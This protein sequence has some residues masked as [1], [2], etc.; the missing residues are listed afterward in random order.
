MVTKFCGTLH[1]GQTRPPV[2]QQYVGYLCNGTV[3]QLNVIGF[4]DDEFP[5]VCPEPGDVGTACDEDEECCSDQW[6]YYETHDHRTA[7]RNSH[8]RALPGLRTRS[9][10]S[11]EPFPPAR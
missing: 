11:Q 3:T 4:L 9:S 1:L 5:D 10:E 6:S 8:G 7:R 2:K